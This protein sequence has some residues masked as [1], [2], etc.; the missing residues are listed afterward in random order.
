MASKTSSEEGA[1]ELGAAGAGGIVRAG[2]PPDVRDPRVAETIHT[3]VAAASGEAEQSIS[4][5][6][7]A[8]YMALEAGF[9]VEAEALI[10]RAKALPPES[11]GPFM[12]QMLRGKIR[13][14][15]ILRD[16]LEA[17]VALIE[18]TLK[19]VPG[20]TPEGRLWA[21]IGISV[22]ARAGHFEKA[23]RHVEE[24]GTPSDFCAEAALAEFFRL[25][26][27]MDRAMKHSDAAL[28]Y[29]KRPNTFTYYWSPRI[30]LLAQAGRAEE[31]EALLNRIEAGTVSEKAPVQR[32]PA[33]FALA[34]ARLALARG[35]L[36]AAQHLLIE[37]RRMRVARPM[38]RN[39]SLRLMAEQA[40]CRRVRRVPEACLQRLD[41]RQ[42]D[43]RCRG[44]RARTCLLRGD[45][46]G[47]V[48]HLA[49]L[50]HPRFPGVAAEAFRFAHEL[51][52]YRAASL[53]ARAAQSAAAKPAR[54]RR[55]A[56]PPPT[57]G[58]PAAGRPPRLI[59][60]SAVIREIEATIGRFAARRESLLLTGETG[61]GKEVVARLL[62]ERSPW[63]AAPFL[64]INCGA[65]SETLIESELFGHAEGAFSGATVAYDGIFI[66]AGEGT[67]LLD[68][69]DSLAPAL[70]AK[71]LRV[72][73]DGELR[74][75][76]STELRLCRARI[77]AALNRPP[78]ELVAQNLL[79][80]DLFY[81]LARL[82]IELPPLRERREDILPLARHFL[83][84]F[85]PGAELQLASGLVEAL[86][87]YDWPGN[88][89]ELKNQIERIVLSAGDAPV[90][91]PDLFQGT[92]SAA[93]AAQAPAHPVPAQGKRLRGEA[94]R[95]QL[96]GL[97]A[98]HG[99][100]GPQKA[101]SL[102]RCSVRTASADLK[103]LAAR[104][105]IRRVI[106]SASLRTSYY[107][108]C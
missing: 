71:L 12:M 95:E 75:V 3:A 80:K 65:L 35:D 105:L 87:R 37:I 45:E 79:R 104:G 72:L 2:R 107:E 52:A 34:R 8:V 31:A 59:G 49:T 94:R 62:H 13:D 23:A 83:A 11:L 64:P 1:E 99:Q 57:E 28:A 19:L 76:G 68:E 77:L 36:D 48:R 50:V 90:L 98:H 40:L 6:L 32:N 66:A 25:T 60:V 106:T 29:P 84:E 86:R 89:R 20:S 61:T 5:L 97:F 55:A 67:V 9:M 58:G 56:G 39:E 38:E 30:L 103:E 24:M 102:L 42:D 78:E 63:S 43:F 10:G 92:S 22:E 100:L 82:R 41:P 81:R 54:H 21:L 47:A 33:L 7:E 108:R 16:D 17:S 4:H 44:I 91:M 69:I 18:E 70:Q 88:V 53:V 85:C 27:E 73:E 15:L 93:P 74:P 51:T 26:G 96:V 101:A 14:F 46:E